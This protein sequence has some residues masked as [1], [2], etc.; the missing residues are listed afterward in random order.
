MFRGSRTDE[1]LTLIFMVL[2]I[3]T[4]ICYFAVTNKVVFFSLGGAAVVIR[5]IQYALRFF[6]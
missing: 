2:A 6:K 1:L 3:A 5:L 4:V